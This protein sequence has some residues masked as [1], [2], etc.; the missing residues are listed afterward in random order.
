MTARPPP[1]TAADRADDGVTVVEVA[2]A[3]AI[4]GIVIAVF[5]AAQVVVQDNLVVQQ[6]RTQNNDQA[7]EALFSLDREIRSGNFVHDPA[8]ESVPNYHLVVYTQANAPTRTPPNQCVEWRIDTTRRLLQR[9][10]DPAIPVAA[11]PW[12]TVAV[13]IVNREGAVPAFTL[14]TSGTSTLVNIVLLANVR[15]SPG[16]PETVRLSSSVTAR[17][18]GSATACAIRP[19]G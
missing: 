16:G 10:W 1:H 11:S 13:D 8:A 7:R 17:N 12:R 3:T 6:R 18:A 4:L 15:Y 19:A 14:S 9:R 5:L 2:L